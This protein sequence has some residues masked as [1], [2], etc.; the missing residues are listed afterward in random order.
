MGNTIRGTASEELKEPAGILRADPRSW[1]AIHEALVFASREIAAG[2]T[3]L[4]LVAQRAVQHVSDR[5]FGSGRVEPSATR[6][7]GK[8][9]MAWQD[10]LYVVN[11]LPDWRFPDAV[12]LVAWLVEC[13]GPGMGRGPARASFQSHSPAHYI[14]GTR[15]LFNNGRHGNGPGWP[16]SREW[17]V[18]DCSHMSHR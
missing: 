7:T 5:G 11:E 16:L 13:G 4:L 1:D 12:L 15:E 9:I 8:K 6:Y 17:T 3:D 14:G 2:S 18:S 10:A